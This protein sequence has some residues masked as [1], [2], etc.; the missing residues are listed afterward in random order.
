MLPNVTSSFL[1][2]VVMP[3]ATS[4]DALVSSNALVTSSFLLLVVMPG[5]GSPASE[6]SSPLWQG[7]GPMNLCAESSQSPSWFT[8]DCV[9]TEQ[10]RVLRSTRRPKLDEYQDSKS[11]F[12]QIF[13]VCI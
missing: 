8:S 1:L 5:Y 12:I 6:G 7:L 10:G 13:G 9:N 2:P 4:S 3:L 11:I